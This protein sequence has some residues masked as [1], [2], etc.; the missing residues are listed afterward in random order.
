MRTEFIKIGMLSALILILGGCPGAGRT[1]KSGKG[2]KTWYVNQEAVDGKGSS[3]EDGFATV[4]AAVDAAGVGDS[5]F[6]SAGV[7]KA[8]DQE[9]ILKVEKSKLRIVGG[10]VKGNK[11]E[12]ERNK[13]N[14]TVF[15]GENN[16]EGIIIE[17][18]NGIA[19]IGID[20]VNMK[21]SNDG[22]GAAIWTKG[23]H[24][25]SSAQPEKLLIEDLHFRS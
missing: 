13:E 2:K 20:F 23:K 5:I 21:A 8:A 17:G 9:Y 12:A 14:R 6:I 22:R 18:G 16:K 25:P 7:Y 10:F 11:T 1:D 4:Q 15:D 19:V 24:G 3:F